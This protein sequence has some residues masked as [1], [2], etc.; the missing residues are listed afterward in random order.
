M[1]DFDTMRLMIICDTTLG[2]WAGML[3]YTITLWMWR[4]VV[5]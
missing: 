3:A 5:K 2:V 4:R 1:F